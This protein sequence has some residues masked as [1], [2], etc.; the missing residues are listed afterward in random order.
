MYFEITISLSR[1]F[2]EEK[3]TIC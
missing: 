3:V 1:A 2:D